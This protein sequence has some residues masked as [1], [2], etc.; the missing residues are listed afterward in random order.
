MADRVGKQ[1]GNYRLLR[2]LGRGSFA[3]VYLAEHLYLER[4]A[5]IKVLHVQMDPEAQERFRREAR[6][7]AHLQ[8]PHIIQ[9]LD[10]GIDEQTP[11]LVMEYTPGGTLRSQHPMGT[12]LPIEQIVTYVKQIASALDYAHQQHVIHRDIK[13]HNLLLTANHEV[14]LS[15]F[16]LAMV[17]QSLDS[18]SLSNPGAGTPQYMA[19]EQ[20]QHHPCAASD[21]YA[22]GV[23]VYEWLA[24]EAPFYG[25]KL[26]EVLSH[27]L[28]QAPPSLRE[29]LPDLPTAVEEVVFKALAKDPEQRFPC[30]MDFAIALE[31]V[32]E[33]TQRLTLPGP[34]KQQTHE[35]TDFNRTLFVPPTA[36]AP[37]SSSSSTQPSLIPPLHK[38]SG[39]IAMPVVDHPTKS[40]QVKPSLA[41]NNRQRFL[42]R[43]RTIWID[44]M[45]DHS[46][47]GTALIALGLQEQL[48]ALANPWHL[49]LQHPDTAP[50]SFPPETLITEIYDAADS[51]LLILGAPGAGK[52]T[53]L[54]ELTRDLLKRAEQDAQHL[55][56]VVFTL[57]SWAAK[58][59]PLAEWMTEELISKYQLPHDLARSWIE[60][61]SILPLLDGLDEIETSKRTAC[62]E[63]INTY[64]Q[65]HSFL[66]LVVSSRSADYVRQTGRLRLSGAVTIQSL[67][68]Q[69]VDDYLAHGGEALWALRVALYQDASLRELAETPLMLSILTLTY[70]D[71]PVEDL[72]RG[73]IAPTRQQIFEHYVQ[74][75]LHRG[76]RKASYQP[77]QTIRLL[78]WLARQLAQS[79]QTQFH[80]EQLQP[81]WLENRR[82]RFLYHCSV[83]VCYGLVGGLF[84]TLFFVLL[85][86]L[87]NLTNP[88][89]YP[90][91]GLVLLESMPPSFALGGGIGL[92]T[93]LVSRR[94]PEIRPIENI[95]WLP[96]RIK[97]SLVVGSIVG[98]IMWLSFWIPQKLGVTVNYGPLRNDL[99][100][101]G[102]VAGLS[103]GLIAAL[104]LFMLRGLSGTRI[105]E[106]NR[107]RPNEGIWR[108]A[109]NGVF[110]GVLVMAFSLLIL[111]VFSTSGFGSLPNVSEQITQIMSIITIVFGSIIN[112]SAILIWWII[113]LR[114]GGSPSIQHAV[115]RLFL[116][117]AQSISWKYSRFLDY[118]T[119]HILL[120]KV[121]GGYIF[122]HRFLQEYFASLDNTPS[123]AET[124][125]QIQQTQPVS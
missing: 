27:H 57:S 50:R 14:M 115:L 26:L 91:S 42:R 1:L 11:Y 85:E 124:K 51:E 111:S 105:D 74:R 59:Q 117:H 53:L 44:G 56:P 119:E 30:V 63:T 66:P 121:G 6:T 35:P 87:F 9:V 47:Q 97:L 92:V 39:P 10:F 98:L 86:L 112:Y 28:Y 81:T 64:H 25:S 79:N 41:Q 106:Q 78:A 109:R 38:E 4:L 73:G 34:T 46:L 69:Q 99:P 32:G 122:I 104:G 58:Q 62:I 18:L 101:G 77:E 43:V 116:W 3:E 13:P 70:H 102:L 37:Q 20:I 90:P 96:S 118:A 114:M 110:W 68:Q 55:M 94:I 103:I 80:L 31:Q 19:P 15:D 107:V 48:D 60:T 83:V 52:T 45:L 108:S 24:G 88:L 95:V 71:M 76:G 29:R 120:R 100:T 23:M 89:I 5:A 36:G 93:G 21:Q 17:Q 67:T 33:I 72:L 2:E 54:L 7:I 113:A 22:L 61:N 8:H 125:V 84:Y 123:R 12:C 49:V 65:E 75:M 40:L 82:S 16:G